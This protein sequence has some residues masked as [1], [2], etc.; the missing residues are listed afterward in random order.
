GVRVAVMRGIIWRSKLLQIEHELGEERYGILK[1]G[2]EILFKACVQ[3]HEV[4]GLSLVIEEIDLSFSLGELERRKRETIAKLR[5]E[6]LFDLNRSLPEPMIMQRIALI[7][8]SGTAAYADFMKHLADN[9]YGYKF[10]VC[11][12]NSI[13]Q[14]EGAAFELRTAL[15]AV[16]PDRFDAVV[17]IR[18][19]GSKLDLEAFNDLELCRMVAQMPIPVMTGIGHEIDVSVLDMI[20]KGHHKTPTAIA[21][22]LIDKCLYFE[23]NLNGFLVNIHKT[24]IDRFSSQKETIGRWKEMLLMR[25]KNKCQLHR[26]AL[27]NAAGQFQRSVSEAINGK[28][29]QLDAHRSNLALLPMR[30]IQNIEASALR[31]LST[32]FTSAAQRGVELMLGRINGMNEAINLVSPERSL[33]RGFSITRMNGKAI[34]DPRDLRPGDVIE[35]EL[36]KGKVWSTIEKTEAHGG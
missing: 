23:T 24:V 1:A 11:L 33:L 8:S 14:G 22:H 30:K 10:H 28:G 12:F 25:P 31:E 2:V 20:A 34:T 3:Y 5:E 36:A 4:H 15:A 18:G 9:E 6:G 26:G 27:H 19:G 35:T 17:F 32:A 16:K 29:K 7:S 21:D 13:V